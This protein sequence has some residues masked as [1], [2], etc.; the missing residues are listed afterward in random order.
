MR[1]TWV[2]V[3]DAS[4]GRLF[5]VGP[6]RTDWQLIRELEHP[7]GRAKGRDLVTDRPGRVKQSAT[8]LRPAMDSKP[9]HQVESEAFAHSI[10]KKLESGLAA[11]AYEQLVLIAPPHFL[12]LL[13]AALSETVAKRVQVTFDKDYTALEVRDLAERIWI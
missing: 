5:R 12:G 2:L 13:R 7:Q 1:A 11:N 10:S 6:R 3:C 4:K 9:P 8:P